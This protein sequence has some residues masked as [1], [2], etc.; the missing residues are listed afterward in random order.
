M[1]PSTL[2][3]TIIVA[4]LAEWMVVDQSVWHDAGARPRLVRYVSRGVFW[5]CIVAMAARPMVYALNL[6]VLRRPGS[7]IED[8]L[9]NLPVVV[10][11]HEDYWP[12]NVRR[13]A[14]MPPS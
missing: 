4:W 13:K 3:W 14:R 7:D 6:P 10:L 1:L 9:P 12:R 5:T 11:H 8:L 2:G